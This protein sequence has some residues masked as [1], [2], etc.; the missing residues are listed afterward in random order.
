MSFCL[1]ISKLSLELLS[2]VDGV[3]FESISNVP[4]NLFYEVRRLRKQ[5]SGDY[6]GMVC[7]G[8]YIQIFS[9]YCEAALDSHNTKGQ[10]SYPAIYIYFI[11]HWRA[12]RERSEFVR[13]KM[14]S[15]HILRQQKKQIVKI[16]SKDD[17][18]E[19]EKAEKISVFKFSKG[20]ISACRPTI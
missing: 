11:G 16:S 18:S 9:Q 12:N 13:E 15:K 7:L 5:F 1:S 17:I 2:V 4:Q 10:N 19:D 14:N 3:S 20:A 6:L 8:V